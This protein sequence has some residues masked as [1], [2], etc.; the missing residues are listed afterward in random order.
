MLD[1]ILEHAPAIMR[2]L[3]FKRT[4]Q[5]I[6][7]S[8]FGVLLYMMF[9][10]RVA[11][12]TSIRAVAVAPPTKNIIQGDA[13]TV[14][15]VKNIVDRSQL[16]S[17]VQLVNTDF[18]SNTRTTAY[19]YA[20]R[21]D[22]QLYIDNAVYNRVAPMQL[23]MNTAAG[24]AEQRLLAVQ[25]N[26]RLIEIIRA[27]FVCFP[28]EST[29]LGRAAPDYPPIA[30]YVCAMSIPPYAGKFAGYLNL[31]LEREPTEDEKVMLRDAASALA[32]DIFDREITR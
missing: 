14:I 7:L 27:E 29:G 10:S 15:A 28:S 18:R 13:E 16:I 2:A 25:S 11:I 31:F 32:S 20:D 26:A 22:L 12:V 4:F 9:D 8:M 24:S 23:F 1:K 17:G 19:I 6:L 5:I 3:T 21:R 30:P